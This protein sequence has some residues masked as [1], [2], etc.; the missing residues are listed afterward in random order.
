M[1][2]IGFLIILILS[3]VV[4]NKI[5]IPWMNGRYEDKIKKETTFWIYESS[6]SLEC[7]ERFK[8]ENK[9]LFKRGHLYT[10]DYPPAYP[11]VSPDG[12]PPLLTLENVCNELWFLYRRYYEKNE[13]K[14]LHK[15]RFSSP[16]E[17]IEHWIKIAEIMNS[18]VRNE[19]TLLESGKRKNPERIRD[20]S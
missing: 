11:F 3:G 6:N 19:L 12:K 5:V 17:E 8:R 10:L 9:H 20:N 13:S 1:V 16:T 4:F 15:D 18:N 2:A 14:P 7:I